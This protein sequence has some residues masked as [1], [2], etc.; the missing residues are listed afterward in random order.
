[1]TVDSDSYNF[2][3][4]FPDDIEKRQT[5][6]LRTR[7][8]TLKRRKPASSVRVS[9]PT[10]PGKR[11]VCYYTNWSVYRK[12]LSKFV[13]ENIN[14]YLCTHLVYAFGGL[15]DEFELTV[16]D[17]YQDI[18]KG[19]QWLIIIIINIFYRITKFSVYMCFLEQE[20]A[21][22]INCIAKSKEWR[23][24]AANPIRKWGYFLL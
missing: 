11:I 22:N 2:W 23:I 15:T 10:L 13:P 1:M 3:Y 5:R 4:L 7:P 16:F 18:E 17:S 8:Q 21:S 19:M 20:F 12:G 9:D 14:P 24:S 6:R